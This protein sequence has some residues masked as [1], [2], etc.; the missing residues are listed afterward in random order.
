MKHGNKKMIQT[1]KNEILSD[2]RYRIYHTKKFITL[3]FLL[4]C[5]K[6][7]SITSIL[8]YRVSEKYFFSS[9]VFF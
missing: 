6:S 4:D 1:I 8:L 5:K 2:L 7:A 9:N 3:A